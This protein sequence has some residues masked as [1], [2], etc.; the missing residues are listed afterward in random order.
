MG[1]L[2][3]LSNSFI[4]NHLNI[5]KSTYWVTDAIFVMEYKDVHS[6]CVIWGTSYSKRLKQIILNHKVALQIK[7]V[8]LFD[9]MSYR[10]FFMVN[11]FRH[12]ECNVTLGILVS[13]YN[14]N[15]YG[16]SSFQSL[17]SFPH[18]LIF[19][20]LHSTVIKGQHILHIC[21]L[22]S[23]LTYDIYTINNSLECTKNLLFFSSNPHV[24]FQAC[25]FS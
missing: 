20:P 14:K 24:S 23:C 25:L 6:H 11:F 16:K 19:F 7:L 18:N 13:R 21:G 17:H 10:F 9:W 15:I 12:Y 8:C 4:L 3:L 5:I 22:L 2:S 1:G